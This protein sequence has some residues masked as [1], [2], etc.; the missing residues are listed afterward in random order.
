[1]FV[2]GLGPFLLIAPTPEFERLLRGF[3]AVFDLGK[4]SQKLL[5]TFVEFH[6]CFDLDVYCVKRFG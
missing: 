3:F 6:W 4:F 5:L 2:F 1:M